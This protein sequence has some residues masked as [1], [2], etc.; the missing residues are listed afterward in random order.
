MK[1]AMIDPSLFTG[2][3]DDSLCT[4]MG[5]QGHEVTLY[6]RPLRSTD[7]IQPQLYK[8]SKRYFRFGEALRPL[9]GEGA[10][11]RA[12]KAA[13]YMADSLI[14]PKPAADVIHYQWLPFAPADRHI[15]RRL[16]VAGTPLVHTVHNAS[17]YHGDAALQGR[18]YASLLDHFDQLIVHGGTTRDALVV[19]GVAADRIA[20]VPHP[21]MRLAAATEQSRAA[22][23]HA[24]L[25]RLL[26]FGTIRPYKGLD[27]LIDACLSLW[28]SGARFELA[29]AGKP[30]MEIAPLLT[31]VTDAGFGDHLRTDLGFLEESRLTAWIESADLLAFPY[32][33]IDSSGAFLSA[34]HHGKATVCTDTGLF[35][36]LPDTSEGKSPVTL[37]PT[38]DAP[39]LAQSLLPLIESAAIR[40][41][42][43]ARAAALG[44]RLG[45]WNEAGSLTVDVYR[46]AQLRAAHRAGA[47]A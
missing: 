41:E 43:G 11:F 2:R 13:E 1:V 35:G 30:F 12:I 7:A 18:G 39:A 16:E 10:A 38:E 21:P 34:L 42:M 29:I 17:A 6:G 47:R 19:Q 32:R 31:T 4:A 8:Y 27:L 24:A 14:G 22:V 23:P 46:E 20:V 26:F 33:H 44:Q 9:I 28:K 40:R 45:D 5:G 15:L 36:S 37:V 3:Y 25:P